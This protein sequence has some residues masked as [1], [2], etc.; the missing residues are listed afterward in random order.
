V[1]KEF[2]KIYSPLI[3]E[4]MSELALKVYTVGGVDTPVILEPAVTPT[5]DINVPIGRVKVIEAIVIV[6][7]DPPDPFLIDCI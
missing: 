6:V 3:V 1:L 7:P 4:L 2:G 5:P